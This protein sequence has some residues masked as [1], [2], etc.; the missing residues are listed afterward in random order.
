MFVA[1]FLVGTFHLKTQLIMKIDYLKKTQ[2]LNSVRFFDYHKYCTHKQIINKNKQI[3][4]ISYWK[5][6]FS[7]NV[8]TYRPRMSFRQNPYPVRI[9]AKTWQWL[10][11]AHTE[12][13]PSLLFQSV[14][15]LHSTWNLITLPWWS[16][17]LLQF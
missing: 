14:C 9:G 17:L 5:I 1:N 4:S 16:L 13:S 7:S 11:S 12:Y 15:T 3:K 2:F 10:L 8:L 6:R